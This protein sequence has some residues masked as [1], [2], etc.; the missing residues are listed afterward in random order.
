[1][2]KNNKTVIIL[3]SSRSDGNTRKVV[4]RVIS[5]NNEID[6]IDLGNYDISYFDYE[7][8]NQGD[9]FQKIAKKLLTYDQIIFATPVYWFSMSAPLKT[10]F[11]RFSDLLH[12]HKEMGR[13]L[14]GKTMGMISSSSG[15]NIN[16]YFRS[17]FIESAKYL[18]MNY[19]GDMHSWLIDDKIPDEV[20]QIIKKFASKLGKAEKIV[21]IN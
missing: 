1:M 20:D 2:D 21:T 16:D 6:L 14:R 4:D 12:L 11:D 18:G 10:F 15:N 5:Y 8:K 17:P 9:D 7:Y 3:G 13:K 19:I